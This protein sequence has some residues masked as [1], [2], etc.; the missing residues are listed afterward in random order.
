MNSNTGLQLIGVFASLGCLGTLVI[1]AILMAVVAK[2]RKQSNTSSLMFH[3]EPNPVNHAVEKLEERKDILGLIRALVEQDVQG[4]TQAARALGELRDPRATGPLAAA[5]R[6]ADLG[7]RVAALAALAGIGDPRCFDTL[8]EAMHDSELHIRKTATLGLW[9]LADPTA[10]WEL[11]RPALTDQRT[12]EPLGQALYDSDSGVV[13][14]AA[15][16]LGVLAKSEDQAYEILKDAVTNPASEERYYAIPQLAK[17]GNPEAPGTLIET[18]PYCS[19]LDRRAILRALEDIGEPVLAP[20]LDGLNQ[21]NPVTKLATMHILDGMLK[22]S[23]PKSAFKI[24]SKME[25]FL[26]PL[27]GALGHSDGPVRSGAATALGYL[28]DVRAVGPLVAALCDCEPEVRACAAHALRQMKEPRA[29]EPLIAALHDTSADV[30]REAAWALG[31]IGD[32]RAVEPLI[33]ALGDPGNE[34][35]LACCSALA[36]LGDRRAVEPLVA[37]LS[38]T[39]DGLRANAAQALGDLGDE[40]AAVRL[41]TALR[42]HDANTR[43]N[44][45]LALGRVGGLEAIPE[46]ERLAQQDKATPWGPGTIGGVVRFAV[47]NIRER[48]TALGSH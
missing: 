41:L 26:A 43:G 3:H 15:G 14:A 33:G 30:R 39:N 6:D 37:V 44:A 32:L 17:T 31:D 42:D 38:D 36:K 7:V 46:L 4:R 25:P 22:N 11:K 34:V 48:S 21:P 13:E 18:F 27:I 35:R 29:V 9:R 8:I 40:R 23:G 16:A 2:K 12:I 1:G 10:R 45:A 19:D 47:E 28:S 24:L 5:T 20:L